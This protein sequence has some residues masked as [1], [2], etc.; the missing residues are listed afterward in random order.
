MTN[1]KA[2]ITMF[3]ITGT[4]FSHAEDEKIND[5]AKSKILTMFNQ[6]KNLKTKTA[7]ETILGQPIFPVMVQNNGSKTSWYIKHPE[8]VIQDHESP[9]GY[10]GIAVSY[11][12][13]GNIVSCLYNFQWV[14]KRF[15]VEQERLYGPV[16][17]SQML[18]SKKKFLRQYWRSKIKQ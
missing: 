13:K 5:L 12:N 11:D 14:E 10:G 7:V 2:I 8:R 18:H 15:I 3:F 9:W 4:S 1:F 6:I 17:Q 16:Y